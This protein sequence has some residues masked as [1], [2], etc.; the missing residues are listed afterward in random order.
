MQGNPSLV[1]KDK[2]DELFPVEEKYRIINLIAEAEG[3]NVVTR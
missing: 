1:N 3:D 2:A